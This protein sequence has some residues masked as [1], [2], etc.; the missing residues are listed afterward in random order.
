MVEKGWSRR[1]ADP[2][3]LPDGRHEG[4]ATGGG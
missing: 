4:V 2:I 3:P 1:F